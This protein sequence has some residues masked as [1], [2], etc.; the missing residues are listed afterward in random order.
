MISK[1]FK[2]VVFF[3]SAIALVS[4]DKDYNEIGTG[5]IGGDHYNFEKVDDLY[6]NAATYQT[7]PVQSN[8]Q[9]TVPF[10]V[11]NDPHFGTTTANFVTQI[12]LATVN[13]TLDNFVDIDSVRLY[14]PYT[15]AI[16]KT[17]STGDHIYTL[18]KIYGDTLTKFDLKIYENKYF[19]RSQDVVDNQTQDQ[20]YYND[21]S[22]TFDGA[23]TGSPKLNNSVNDQEE[24]TSFQFSSLEIKQNKYDTDV[25]TTGD[26]TLTRQAPGLYVK[27]D[28]LFFKSKVLQAPAGM[29]ANNNVFKNYFRGLH[30]KLSS[31]T[32]ARGALNMVD[33]TK[34][35]VTIY[36]RRNIDVVKNGVTTTVLRRFE[37]KLNLTGNSVSLLDYQNPPVIPP[38]RLVVKGGQGTLTAIDILTAAERD[39]MRNPSKWL[40][41][42]ANL[43]FNVDEEAQGSAVK[44]KRLYLYDMTHSQPIIDYNA[45]LTT[46][47]NTELNKSTFSGILDSAKVN[48]G[49]TYKYFYKVRVTNYIRSLIEKPDSTLVRLG[50]SVTNDITEKNMVFTKNPISVQNADGS[51]TAYKKVPKSSVINPFGVVLH[52]PNDATDERLKLIIYYTKPDEG[53][54]N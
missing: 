12:E 47:A 13:P 38:T 28:S 53:Q 35:A 2:T 43:I 49:S 31:P 24:N 11:Y 18:G 19:L 25:T 21:M 15:A 52:G 30:F 34:G 17:K 51:T 27:L 36:Y 37:L 16:K 48:N 5:L 3:V 39:A 1:V 20:A 4:C 42:E 46:N 33:F 9:T 40:I 45:D 44:P 50:L 32:T 41:N 29:L 6:L 22:A 14:V 10:G 8:G 26:T 7:G 54:S 23:N